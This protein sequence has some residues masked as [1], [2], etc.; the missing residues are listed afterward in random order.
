MAER[1]DTEYVPPHPTQRHRYPSTVLSTIEHLVLLDLLGSPLPLIHSYYLSTAWLFDALVSAEQRLDDAGLLS[2]TTE[3]AEGNKHKTL[4]SFF[5]PRGIAG[6]SPY[7]PIGDDHM[8]FLE[9]GVNVLH[10]IPTP[11]P[12]VWHT[13]S[14]SLPLY[15][16]LALL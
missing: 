7:G 14:V 2:A 1:W 12:T 13:L 6:T 8:P 4:P 5:F 3:E 10:V 15:V 9:R 11:F 16:S